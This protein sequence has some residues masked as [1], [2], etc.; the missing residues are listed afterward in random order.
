MIMSYS[1]SPKE[2]YAKAHGANLRI[3]TKSAAIICAAIRKKPATRAKRLLEDLASEK[4]SLAGKYYTKTVREILDL[5]KSC[6]K[7]AEFLGLDAHRLMVHAAV[8]KGTHLRRRRRRA[9]FGSTLKSSNLEI[10]LI[11][12][13]KEDTTKV[14]KKAG[15]KTKKEASEEER[16]VRK[17]LTAVREKTQE[18]KERVREKV[19]SA[20]PTGAAEKEKT[21][22]RAPEPHGDTA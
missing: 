13:G 15:T 21:E 18:L 6:E 19:P 9:A 12:R 3:S 16:A 20:Q 14:A 4:R 17:E 8:S 10:M 22:T 2:R 11:E 7:N 1:F 5:F